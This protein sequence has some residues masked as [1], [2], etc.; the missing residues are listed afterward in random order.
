MRDPFDNDHNSYWIPFADFLAGV[1]SIFLVVAVLL[2]LHLT[3]PRKEKNGDIT[4]PGAVLVEIYWAEDVDVD[5]WVKSPG[6]DRPVGY[7][8]KQGIYFDLL[9]D[10]LGFEYEK[11][12]DRHH[13]NAYARSAPPG[14][15][16]VNIHMY[17]IR[18]A[19]ASIFPIKVDVAVQVV[20][21]KIPNQEKTVT[22]V[23][24]TNLNLIALDQEATVVRF[25]LDADGEIVPGS[26][27]YEPMPLRVERNSR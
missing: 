8:R 14:E 21:S 27:N 25:R 11:V 2:T 3:D 7:S 6:D 4:S 24:H 17:S 18:G 16:V 13:E 1:L 19:S 20:K 23:I 26:L 5:L 22:N 10:D 12:A 15:Y 9:R